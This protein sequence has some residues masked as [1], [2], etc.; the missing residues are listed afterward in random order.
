MEFRYVVLMPFEEVYLCAYCVE[1]SFVTALAL[2]ISSVVYLAYHITPIRRHSLARKHA[3][4]E[5]GRS[6]SR[7]KKTPVQCGIKMPLPFCRAR[8][9]I[10]NHSTY[11]PCVLS[12]RSL[13][14]TVIECLR[15][16]PTDRT[17]VQELD[18]LPEYG[19][20]IRQREFRRPSR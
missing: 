6:S 7:V 2:T 11:F 19:V 1:W 12:E 10:N 14:T 4:C 15:T 5:M 20:R 17:Q 18:H 13:A 9:I 8:Y 16:I 3:T